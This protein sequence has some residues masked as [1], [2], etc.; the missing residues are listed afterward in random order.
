MTAPDDLREAGC[1]LWTSIVADLGDG[2]RFDARELAILTAAARQADTVADLE[3]AVAADGIMVRGAAG[4]TRLNAAV[5]EL[6]KGRVALARL[7]GNVH[8]PDEDDKSATV[9]SERGRRA[10]QARW[11]KTLT[12]AER[13]RR[14]R[15]A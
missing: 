9:A 12:N 15:H 5:V 3:A 10:A 6:R 4:Q 1:A 11:S 8:L 13:E 14:L 2:W 7:L